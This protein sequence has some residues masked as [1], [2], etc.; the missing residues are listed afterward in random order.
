[1]VVVGDTL[2]CDPSV[3]PFAAVT[4]AAFVKPEFVYH[5]HVAPVP[6]LPP[7]S[8]SVAEPPGQMLVEPEILVGATDAFNV[9]V[10]LTL[11][12]PTLPQVPSART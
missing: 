3:V 8:A 4:V 6:K 12:D 7:T 10:A 2:T 11:E 1:M 9:T 5:F